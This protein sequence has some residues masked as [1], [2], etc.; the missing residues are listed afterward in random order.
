MP[1]ATCFSVCQTHSVNAGAK[2][3]HRAAQKSA[4]LAMWVAMTR[5]GQSA[6]GWIIRRRDKLKAKYD[7]EGG[8]PTFIENAYYGSDS[9][10]VRDHGVSLELRDR[11]PTSLLRIAAGARPVAGGEAPG[12][13]AA[14]RLAVPGHQRGDAADVASQLLNCWSRTST[15]RDS[16]SARARQLDMTAG[17]ATY[18]RSRRSAYFSK[19]QAAM[20]VPIQIKSPRHGA[21]RERRIAFPKAVLL[22]LAALVFFVPTSLADEARSAFDGRWWVHAVANPGKCSDDIGVWIRVTNRQVTYR[23]LLAAFATGTVTSE[24]KLSLHI[25]EASVVGRLAATTGHGLWISPDCK[26]TWKATR[27]R[28]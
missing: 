10:S 5:R 9:E 6:D 24:G 1:I 19:W 15:P 11:P 21:Q 28:R 17:Q 13:D 2:P 22:H 23:G 27:E 12:C 3:G 16:V 26:G 8:S 20:I 14:A 4:T 7:P 25:G 18:P